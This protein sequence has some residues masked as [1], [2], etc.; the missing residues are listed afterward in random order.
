MLLLLLLV[1][2]LIG[3]YIWIYTKKRLS[4]TDLGP[5]GWVQNPAGERLGIRSHILPLLYLLGISVL[6]FSLS[7]PEVVVNL[8]RIEGTVILAFDVSN[9]MAAD[10]F[11]PTRIEAAKT[12][13]RSFVENQPSTI[14]LGVVAFSNGGLVVQPPTDDQ[15]AVLDTIDRLNPQG[16]TS[17]GQGIFSA[18]NAIAGE[19]IEI[20][21]AGF[22]EGA[23]VDIGKF[24]SAVVLLLTDGENTSNLDPLDIAQIAAE[25]GVRIF[26]VGIGSEEGAIL[27]IE[28]Y[29]VSTQLDESMLQDI[30][31]L[32][33]GSY[34]H[35]EDEE[36]LHEIYENVD[37]H[38]TISGEKTE[39]TAIFASLGLLLFLIGGM[40]ALV[41]LGRMPL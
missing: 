8:P 30:A 15:T 16:A 7:R 38:L 19:A 2:L 23:P 22:E 21:P 10:D 36:S 18:L 11:A 3:G 33:N 20:D 9:S 5:L 26:P 32:T 35:A 41:W 14:Q 34:Y 17:L 31:S 25:A 28:G 6:L 24:P 37:L 13:A 4:L 27:Q 29:S 12:A 39:V 1:P 40:L